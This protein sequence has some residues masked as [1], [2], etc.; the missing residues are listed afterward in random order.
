M[1]D[2]E[3]RSM[4]VVRV[5]PVTIWRETLGVDLVC[6]EADRSRVQRFLQARMPSLRYDTGV[7]DALQAAQ[8]SLVTILLAQDDVEATRVVYPE[9]TTTTSAAVIQWMDQRAIAP[10]SGD[11]VVPY[12]QGDATVTVHVGTSAQ[13]RFTVDWVP[14]GDIYAEVRDWLCT[15]IGTAAE[16][17]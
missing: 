5:Y 16:T 6:P 7:R 12:A 13:L 4:R 17:P 1:A 11:F 8:R 9:G 3:V 10:E 15:L 2:E 14:E